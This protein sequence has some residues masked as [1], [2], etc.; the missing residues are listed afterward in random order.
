MGV[1]ARAATLEAMNPV[2]PKKLLLSK[3]TAVQ[4]VDREKHF[5]VARLLLPDDPAAPLVWVE[6][7]AVYS[8]SRRTLAWR[9][10]KDVT[11]WRQGWV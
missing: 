9:E 8:G 6:L 11:R 4:P 10:L 5:L 7:E 3:W 1:G 2:H